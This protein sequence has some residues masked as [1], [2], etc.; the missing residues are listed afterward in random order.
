MNH[1]FN[2][3]RNENKLD[4]TSSKFFSLVSNIP[5]LFFDLNQDVTLPFNLQSVRSVTLRYVL[6]SYHII[7]AG[8]EDTDNR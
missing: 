7:F 3:S 2:N 1:Q 8:S 6:T 4:S 5:I